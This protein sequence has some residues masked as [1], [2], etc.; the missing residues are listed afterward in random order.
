MFTYLHQRMSENIYYVYTIYISE[1][2]LYT[3]T[4]ME[5]FEMLLS[6][7]IPLKFSITFS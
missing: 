1:L 6:F 2:I 5:Q 4:G 7:L 3:Y